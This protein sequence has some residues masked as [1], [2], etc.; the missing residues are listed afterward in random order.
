MA[1]RPAKRRKTEDCHRPDANLIGEQ[2]TPDAVGCLAVEWVSNAQL[3][4]RGVTAAY[5][6]LLAQCFGCDLLLASTPGGGALAWR[7]GHW[8]DEDVARHPFSLTSVT[9]QAT[10]Q[11][12][13][14]AR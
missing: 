13:V 6:L 7:F 11:R 9:G 5:G 14:P 12:Q 2:R 8:P 4:E 1:R 10:C 3:R